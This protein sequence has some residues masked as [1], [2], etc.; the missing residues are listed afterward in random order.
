MSAKCQTRTLCSVK[1][2]GV[3]HETFAVHP[4]SFRR[5]HLDRIPS[6][7]P[8][9]FPKRTVNF[10]SSEETCHN[11]YSSKRL[12]L[13]WPRPLRKIFATLGPGLV[14]QRGDRMC[15][16]QAKPRAEEVIS[17]AAFILGVFMAVV[18]VAKPLRRKAV[19]R[20]PI[21][22]PGAAAGVAGSQRWNN[23]W[24][25]SA[26]LAGTV[27]QVPT[28]PRRNHVSASVKAPGA[29][30]CWPQSGALHRAPITPPR[31]LLELDIGQCLSVV[32]THNKARILLFDGQGGG[33]RRASL[34]RGTAPARFPA[35]IAIFRS[36]E[37][38][39]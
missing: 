24:P 22:M 30:R 38:F 21:T 5:Y 13:L 6:I 33:K 17:K 25:T 8:V 10:C 29:W 37:A 34:R 23:A 36:T 2:V 32:V 4:R 15:M 12:S 27:D 3:S 18:C 20:V 16:F 14:I 9:C 39:R 11:K 26:G 28:H 1:R 7:G 19:R 31:L 35:G